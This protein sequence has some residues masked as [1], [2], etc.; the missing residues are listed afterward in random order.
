MLVLK[1]R[2]ISRAFFFIDRLGHQNY[3]LLGGS[4]RLR[5]HGLYENS[6]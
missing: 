5:V 3:S 6:A 1:T 4:A 2:P